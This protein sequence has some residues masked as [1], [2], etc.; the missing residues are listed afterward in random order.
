MR[1][2][3][4]RGKWQVKAPDGKIYWVKPEHFTREREWE[5]LRSRG[6]RDRRKLGS[7]RATSAVGHRPL[8]LSRRSQRKKETAGQSLRSVGG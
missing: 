4:S 7:K 8:K 2:D 1:E 3:E 6:D 5:E